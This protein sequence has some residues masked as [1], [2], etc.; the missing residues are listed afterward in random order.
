MVY[1]WLNRI[2]QRL[3]PTP[4]AL[5]LG[6]DP[7][8]RGLCPDCLADL[9]RLDPCCPRCALPLAAPDQVC[10][11][12]QRH[13]PHFDATV[14]LFRYAPP[15]D[16]LVHGLKFGQALHFAP[17]F[18]E[19]LA[20]HLADRPPP[21]CIVPVPLHPRRQRER[22]YNQA[23]EI[24]RPLARRLGT[25]LDLGSCSR[26]RATSAQTRLDARQRRHNLR[27]AFI[28]NRCPARHVALL[29]DVMTT[30]STLNELAALLRCAGA[31]RIEAWVCARTA[32]ERDIS[33]R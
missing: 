26:V 19:L 20:A 17:L 31:E 30:G 18:A 25:R 32:Q 7:H 23:V 16:R 27:N 33:G 29:D 14:A 5:C 24:A 15:V 3:W 22:G 11:R 10:G 12:C 13:P 21:A 4:C 1:H 2:Q 28:V 8:G 9:P 6:R